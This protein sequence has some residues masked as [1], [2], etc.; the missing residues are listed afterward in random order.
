LRR[1][2]RAIRSSGGYLW[3]LGRSSVGGRDID[4]IEAGG[5]GGQLLCIAPSLD[6]VVVVTAGVYD[7]DGQGQQM[8]AADTAIDDFVLP[9]A[10]GVAPAQTR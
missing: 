9:A 6:L 8:L 4:W 2:A 1:D 3:W 10:L 5:W 7:F